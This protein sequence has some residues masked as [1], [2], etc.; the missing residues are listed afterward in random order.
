MEKDI[1]YIQ[2]LKNIYVTVSYYIYIIQ[3]NSNDN[4]K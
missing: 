1:V 2:Q 4:K 3:D